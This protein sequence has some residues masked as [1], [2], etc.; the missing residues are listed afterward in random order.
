LQKITLK[1]WSKNNSEKTY[2]PINKN[3][4]GELT[5]DKFIRNRLLC[6]RDLFET[7]ETKNVEKY[8][9]YHLFTDIAGELCLEYLD[10]KENIQNKCIKIE[11]LMPLR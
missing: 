3:L 11:R 2:L 6:P 1:T 7:D 5:K 8:R 4:S 10:Y 9:G